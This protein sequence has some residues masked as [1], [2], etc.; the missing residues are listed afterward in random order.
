MLTI[1]HFDNREP[2]ADIESL[3]A[4]LNRYRGVSVS[5]E[6]RRASSGLQGVDYVDV[7]ASGAVLASHRGRGVY[8]FA[9][10]ARKAD[11]GASG[12]GATAE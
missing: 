8:D 2:C 6:Y 5:I 12:Q 1:R 7:T 9:E 10:L 4:A 11:L 3:K